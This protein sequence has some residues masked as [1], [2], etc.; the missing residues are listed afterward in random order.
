MAG[1]IASETFDIVLGSRILGGMAVKMGMPVYKYIANRCLTFIQNIFL[2]EKLSEYHTGLRA[3][4]KDALLKIPLLENSDDFLFD[5]E[6]LVQA[7]YF[8][9]KIGEITS[10]CRY[11]SESSSIGFKRSIFY[12]LGV[13]SNCIKFKL[14]KLRLANFSIFNP[15]GRKYYI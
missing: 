2:D 13:L 7:I 11:N 4:S 3:F 5:N 8:G 15:A 14:Q 1:L 10:W 9:Y 6:M 12:G